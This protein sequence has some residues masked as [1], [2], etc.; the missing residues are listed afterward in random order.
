MYLHFFN[1]RE[2]PFNLTPDPRFLFLSPQHEEALT[3]LLYGIQERK[4][5][6]EITG[7]VGTGKTILCRALLDRLDATVSTALIFNSYL[8]ELELLQAITHD[9]GLTCQ[10]TTR[11]GYV[12]TLNAY[13]L[14]E[15]AAGRNAVVLIDEAQNLEPRVLEQLRML[16]N[17]ETER[18]KLMQVVLL[19]QPELR[20]R[21]STPQLRQLDQR[22]AVRYHLRALTRRETQPYIMH[23]LSVAGAANTIRFTRRALSLMHRRC[24]GIPRCI[25]LLCDRILA[26][27]FVR[28]THRI[29]ARLVRQSLR[30][31]GG[32]WPLS[33]QRAFRWGPV[34]LR[35][36]V[37]SLAGMVLLS[38]AAVFLMLPAL[39][40]QLRPVLPQPLLTLAPSPPPPSLPQPILPPVSPVRF[41]PLSPSLPQRPEAVPALARALWHL[42]DQVKGQLDR[43]Q[44]ASLGSRVTL[45]ISSE[46][47]NRLDIMPIQVGFPQLTRISRPCFIEVASDTTAQLEL[48]VLVKGL[49]NQV[50]VYREPEGLVPV[51]LT[52]LQQ[53]W[54][55][56][57]YLTLTTGTYHGLVLRQ[58]M[59]GTRVQTLQHILKELGYFASEPTGLFDTETYQAVMSFQRD[60]QLVVD[61]YIGWQTMMMLLHIGGHDLEETT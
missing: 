12:D 35:A 2:Q 51:T 25:N 27:A 61:G 7:E 21:L 24:A 6:I 19:G 37:V 14:E 20:D 13:L 40:E 41:V 58:G 44:A 38:M 22:I 49:E 57:L 23:R 15:F 1:L 36:T 30:D 8:T 4:G 31:L 42:K 48:W 47:R 34:L 55:G 45:P 59:S 50:V 60:N 56:K 52:Q 53:I 32:G 11:K 9:F 3:H 33:S 46:H 16:S 10:D 39:Q 43:L 54:Y 18:G 17:L 26:A 29:T 5:F 28:D